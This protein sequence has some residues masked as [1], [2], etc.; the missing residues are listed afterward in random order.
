[1]YIETKGG[2]IKV[3]PAVHTDIDEIMKSL[4]QQ[5]YSEIEAAYGQ[6]VNTEMLEDVA[7]AFEESIELANAVTMSID[8]ES[9]ALLDWEKLD[10]ADGYGTALLAKDR[11]YRRDTLRISTQVFDHLQTRLN[12][13][14]FLDTYIDSAEV[15]RWLSLMGFSL[16]NCGE[17]FSTYIKKLNG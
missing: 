17:E 5:S 15:K 16:Q 3:H 10:N 6:P 11:F 8:N 12:S 13:T 4:S 1:M 9:V 7:Y 14:L 2:K